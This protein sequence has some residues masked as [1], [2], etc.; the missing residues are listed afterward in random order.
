MCKSNLSLR[1]FA[2]DN[3]FSLSLYKN[4][5]FWSFYNSFTMINVS[6]ICLVPSF[7]LC[8]LF[9]YCSFFEIFLMKNFFCALESALDNLS[10]IVYRKTKSLITLAWGYRKKWRAVGQHSCL[11][12][13]ATVLYKVL[14]E[15]EE[16]G[17]FVLLLSNLNLVRLHSLFSKL[18]PYFLLTD[19]HFTSQRAC[20]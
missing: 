6:F 8:L 16:K 12:R 19:L 20:A 14:E 1:P 7:S 17:H 2:D 18:L 11:V 10:S 13:T 3:N 4:A 9:H 5:L 15:I